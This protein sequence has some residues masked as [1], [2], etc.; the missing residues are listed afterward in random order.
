MWHAP[1]DVGSV[2]R[3]RRYRLGRSAELAAILALATKGFRPIGRRVVMPTGEID[4]IVARGRRVA[5]VEVKARRTEE[6]AEA[7]IGDAQRRRIHR[8]A[9]LWLARHPEFRDYDITFDIVFVLP[10]RWP[11]HLVNA[12]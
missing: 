9:D 5:F 4:L 7:S 3:R 12:L 10:W 2:E 11:R 8:A 6:A 1:R